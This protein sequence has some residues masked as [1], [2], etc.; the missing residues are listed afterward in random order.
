MKNSLLP[1]PELVQTK[2]ELMDLLNDLC[3]QPR[4]AVDTESNSLHAYKEEVCLIQ[5]SYPGRDVLVDPIKLGSIKPLG[6]LFTDPAIQK[7]MHGA[8]YDIGVL[9]R[10]FSIKISNLFD[11]RIACRTLGW[12][13]NGLRSLVESMFEVEINKR[14]QRANWGKRPLSDEML[15]YARLDTHYL[16][17]IRERLVEL[18]KESDLLEE[19][20]EFCE[21]MTQAD[22]HEISF[23]PNGFWRI[24]NARHLSPKGLAILRELYV[25][26][27]QQA[28]QMNRPSFKVIS[29]KTLV[30][31][32]NQGP[33]NLEQLGEISGMTKRQIHRHGKLLLEAVRRGQE[34]KPPRY[35]RSKNHY[36]EDISN[37]YDLLHEWRKNTARARGVESDII[38]PRDVMRAIAQKNPGHPSELK[39]LMQP[40]DIRFKRYG[41]QILEIIKQV[42]KAR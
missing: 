28:R 24:R 41:S 15:D 2:N 17:E 32:S 12:K 39:Q 40:L 37:R 7:V 30:E 14:F 35:P 11:T 25:Y 26:R 34:A 33:G 16:I 18:L 36:R 6:K 19:M 20:L 21:Y 9:K 13:N 29:D 42:E 27:D 22:A 1:P 8:E 10:D 3:R 31:I 4:L 5:F 38:L 23:D